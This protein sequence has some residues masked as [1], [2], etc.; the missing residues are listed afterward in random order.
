LAEVIF[1]VSSFIDLL[2]GRREAEAVHFVRKH[3]DRVPLQSVY[4]GI[5]EAGLDEADRRSTRGEL[6]AAQRDFVG[7]AVERI[8]SVT[9]PGLMATQSTREAVLCAS[10]GADSS[11]AYLGIA[12]ALLMLEGYDV[13]QPSAESPVEDLERIVD[14]IEPAFCIFSVTSGKAH[15]ALARVVGYV[16]G[17]RVPE[18]PLIVV[19]TKEPADDFSW[20]RLDVDV[21]AKN[22]T[23]AVEAVLRVRTDARACKV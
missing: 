3:G 2:A 23:A 22:A 12:A 7:Q 19:L 17:R 11:S 10:F 8:M 9:T 15:A 1:P 21:L 20:K 6:T 14:E 16:Q 18:R 13:C 5:Y 4:G